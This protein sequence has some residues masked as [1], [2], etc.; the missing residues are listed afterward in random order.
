[1]SPCR[2]PPTPKVSAPEVRFRRLHPAAK[3]RRRRQVSWLS[4][5]SLLRA[6]PRP[7]ASVAF[8]RRGSPLTVAGTAADCH[9]VPYSLPVRGAPSA[10][11]ISAPQP[12][13]QEGLTRQSCASRWNRAGFQRSVA[14]EIARPRRAAERASTAEVPQGRNLQATTTFG[15]PPPPVIRPS[16]TW[17]LRH[18]GREPIRFLQ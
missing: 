11:Q 10:A 14:L 3:E 2:M 6:F 4:G 12:Q 13:P 5:Y 8:L 1:M 17:P 18:R 15:R 7:Q 16:K 9:R